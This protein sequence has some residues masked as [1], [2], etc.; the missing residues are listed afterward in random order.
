MARI[1]DAEK[2][3]IVAENSRATITIETVSVVTTAAVEQ[4]RGLTKAT[5]NPVDLARLTEPEL[6]FDEAV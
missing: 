6:P 2:R 5:R 1:K 4:S 3:R